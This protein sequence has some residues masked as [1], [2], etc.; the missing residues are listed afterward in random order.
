MGAESDSGVT[1]SGGEQENALLAQSCNVP[2]EQQRLIYKGQIL[3]NDQTLVSYG[4][5]TDHTVHVVRGSTPTVSQP[6]AGA[7]SA[8]N[9]N[10][11]GVAQG[12]S[13]RVGGAGGAGLGASLFLGLGLGALG[14]TGASG[15][16]GVRLPEFEQM[17]Q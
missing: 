7:T 3:K 8:E 17:Q 10:N 4:L 9:A 5:R 12:A 6:S 1:M 16:F 15:L 14:G 11:Y 2:S 13:P